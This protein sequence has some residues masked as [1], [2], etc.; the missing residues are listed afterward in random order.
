MEYEV[1]ISQSAGVHVAFKI[2][3]SKQPAADAVKAS[4]Q[5]NEILRAVVDERM[6]WGKQNMTPMEKR[7]AKMQEEQ[8][9]V[10]L[11][12]WERQKAASEGALKLLREET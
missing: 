5:A 11:D 8:Q 7:L 3:E 6:E 12:A 4:K 9:Q 1:T 2:P 10:A